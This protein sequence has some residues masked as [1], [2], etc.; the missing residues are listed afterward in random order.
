MKK[1]SLNSFYQKIIRNIRVISGYTEKKYSEFLIK[2]CRLKPFDYYFNNQ[3]NKII[4]HK[5]W[6]DE[7]GNS[8][9]LNGKDFEIITGDVE[10][11]DKEILRSDIYENLDIIKTRKM[12]KLVCFLDTNILGQQ[13][14]FVSFLGLDDYLRTFCIVD[15]NIKKI[16]SLFL[17]T[18][19][20]RK[21]YEDLD[22]RYF[23]EMKIKKKELPP[24][25]H[26]ARGWLS[27]CPVH[28]DFL[29]MIKNHYSHLT[30]IFESN[31][32]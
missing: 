16:S 1:Y 8:L 21:I 11:L 14:F 22:I 17:G 6:F 28:S 15:N 26:S 3:R 13:V 20:I 24:T 12:S 31:K 2:S 9:V 27:Y 19:V 7:Y 30:F 32:N 25:C 29:N 4:L 18:E 10:L 23:S 5:K